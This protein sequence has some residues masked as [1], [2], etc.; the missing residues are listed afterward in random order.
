MDEA[1]FDKFALEYEEM[2]RKNIRISGE[3]PNYF[4]E[5]KIL[6]IR[7]EWISGPNV[8]E[9]E[10]VLDFGGGIGAS[11]PFLSRHFPESNLTIADVSRRSLSIAQERGVPKLNCLHFDGKTLP[12]DNDSQDIVLAACVF[13]HIPA[14]RHEAIIRDIRR[15]LTPGGSVFIFEHNPWNPLTVRAVRTRPLDE[16]AILIPAPRLRACVNQAGFKTDN[17]RCAGQLVEN[18]R[19]T[20]WRFPRIRVGK[21]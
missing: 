15:V 12:L 19:L 7:C 9:P 14:E 8:A 18:R 17:R 20:S 4:A 3:D 16:N 5:Y 21:I 10:N 1:E 2:H 11:L 6:D 13:H